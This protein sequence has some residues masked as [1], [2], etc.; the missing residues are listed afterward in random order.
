LK[1]SIRREK[2]SEVFRGF[3]FYLHLIFV[4]GCFTKIFFNFNLKI[5]ENRPKGR[6]LSEGLDKGFWLG[7]FKLALKFFSILKIHME[8]RKRNE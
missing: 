4:R 1:F 2:S 3:L 6:F 7:M 5:K 8:R